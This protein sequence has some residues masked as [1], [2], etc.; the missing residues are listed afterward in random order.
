MLSALLHFLG[1]PTFMSRARPMSGGEG[2]GRMKLME[3][4]STAD[5]LPR[6]LDLPSWKSAT[7]H[8]LAACITLIFL[9]SGV[10]KAVEPFQF[11]QLA[12]QLLVP[13][14]FSTVLTIALAVGEISSALLILVPRFRRW[15][16]ILSSF[17][18]LA[19]MIYIGA[20]YPTLVG[21]DC[22]CFPLVKRAV[23]P[24]FFPE[25][26]AMLAAAVLAGLWAKPSQSLRG[27]LVIL[28]AVAAFVGVSFGVAVTHQTGAKAPESVIADGQP[29]DLGQGRF[30]I[31]F[32]DPMCSHCNAA[33]KDM[34][35]LHWKEDVTVLAVP[36]SGQQWAEAFLKDNG[37]KAKTSLELAK[38][39][40]AFPFGDPPYGVVIEHG[41]MTGPVPHYEENGEPAVTL[42]QL[43]VIE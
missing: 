26:G 27:A 17:L 23:T 39:K 15:G 12:E 6:P 36:V 40:A 31:F 18:F 2:L 14:Q 37:L 9:V 38:L 20:R 30:F 32:Y 43:G 25:D 3:S 16:A 5:S 34:G 1:T 22:S 41:R 4:A 8:V 19:F 21:K 29:L 11:R 7:S 33:A 10:W 42:R 13:I 35:T 28:G 24:A